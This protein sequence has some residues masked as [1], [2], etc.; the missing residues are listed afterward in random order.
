MALPAD[1]V[2]AQIEAVAA[3]IRVHATKTG[4]LATAAIVEAVAAA[5][6]SSTCRWSSS[7]RSWSRRAARDC[8][9]MMASECYRT[10]LPPRAPGR[11]AEHSRG[12]GLDRQADQSIEDARAAAYEI[13]SRSGSAVVIKGGHAKGDQLVDLLFDGEMFTELQTARIATRNTHGTGCTFAS[14]IAA[15][16]RPRSLPGGR[17]RSGASLCRRCNRACLADRSGPRAS[18]SL[19]E[20]SWS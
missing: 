15:Q 13:H 18:G 12:R 20:G 1:L 19:L 5:I 14:A 3:D 10:E 2:T 11:D 6:K 8:W 16:P 17:S 4:M 7:I 9:T